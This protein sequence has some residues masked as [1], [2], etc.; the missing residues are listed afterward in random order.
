MP[1]SLELDDLDLPEPWPNNPRKTAPKPHFTGIDSFA[2][3]VEK[4]HASG[5]LVRFKAL[6]RE[7][8]TQ[9]IQTLIV[10]IANT[11]DPLML[12]AIHLQ[13]E[14]RN[15]APVQR[16]PGRTDAIQ[17]LFVSWCADIAW[18]AKRNPAYT[19]HF[20]SWRRLFELKPCGPQWLEVAY[21]LFVSMRSRSLAHIT[22]RA[23][24]LFDYQRLDL[25]TV[26][27]MAMVAARRQLAPAKLESIKTRLLSYALAHRD[28]SGQH[29]PDDI[30]N[31]RAALYRVHLLSS[32]HAPTTA[33]NWQALTGQVMTRQ[34]VSGH[35]NTVAD[36]LRRTTYLG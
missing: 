7:L 14:K 6:A 18:F 20:K 5:D 11:T 2:R 13:L 23:L 30:A 26:P 28:K 34:T 33:I 16:W 12:W 15:I 1:D 36:I 3:L 21:W 22:A 8:L 27:T 9:D 32:N 17:M 4:K 25:L 31:R 35:L 10:R 24:A 29:T 19:P